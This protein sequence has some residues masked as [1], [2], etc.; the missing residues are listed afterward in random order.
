MEMEVEAH[1]RGSI[2][3]SAVFNSF[4]SI[5]KSRIADLRRIASGGT[6]ILNDG[7]L[8]PDLIN[9]LS[10]EAVKSAKH[11]LNMC[12]RALDYCPPV[13]IDF[14]DYLRAL[15]TVDCDVFPNDTRGYRIAFIDAFRQHGIYP[16]S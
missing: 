7:E 2:L 11:V 10:A 6:G 1:D 4:V 12:I 8:H 5:Y 14:G 16:T 3:V 15:I 9:R 13:D